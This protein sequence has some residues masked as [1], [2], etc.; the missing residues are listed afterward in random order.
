MRRAVL[1]VCVITCPFGGCDY[2][3]RNL[4]PDEVGAPDAAPDA[5]GTGVATCGKPGAVVDDFAD[6]ITGYQWQVV[7]TQYGDIYESGGE[8]VITPMYGPAGYHAIAGVD[9]RESGI[10][11]EVPTMITAGRATFAASNRGMAISLVQEDGTLSA[12]IDKTSGPSSYDVPYDPAA[13]RWWR[14]A[15][16]GGTVA[17]STSPDG[18]AWAPVLTGAGVPFTGAVAVSMS[19]DATSIGPTAGTV[20]FRNLRATEGGVPVGPAPWCKGAAFTDEF[21]GSALSFAWSASATPGG[22]CDPRVGGD[23]L[24]IDQPGA[25]CTGT[26]ASTALYDLTDSS[27]VLEVDPINEL[28]YYTAAQLTITDVITRAR[29]SVLAGNYQLCGMIGD[30]DYQCTSYLGASQRFWRLRGSGTDLVWE[31]SPDRVDWMPLRTQYAPVDLT[32]VR[33]SISSYRTYEDGSA[34]MY[35]A[36][37]GLNP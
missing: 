10:E 28:V 35:F 26:V 11:V 9:L 21:D 8:L 24:H 18:V 1:A 15:E 17:V 33:I 32:R 30:Y 6:G 13:H 16:S 2:D 31:A 29:A 23:K 27:V 25:A 34:A 37:P 36:S 7:S 14:I 20:T 3:G 12:R 19:A 5:G 4:G 22:V